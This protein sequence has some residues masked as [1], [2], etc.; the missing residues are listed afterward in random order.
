MPLTLFVINLVFLALISILYLQQ[1]LSVLSTRAFISC[2][3][4]ARASM[5]S[6][7][8]NWSYFC[9]LPT[10]SPCSSRASVII[11]SRKLLKRVSERRHPCL[12][13]T[14]VLNHS[15]CCSS[16]EL[17]HSPQR[18]KTSLV[19]Q[20]FF[21]RRYFPCISLAAL[22]SAVSLVIFTISMSISSS[23]RP[24]SGANFPP[25]VA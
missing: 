11:R 12:T 5:S 24:I 20:G 17:H 3:D 9:H 8:A 23:L 4:S 19:I 7:P 15:L 14:V 2:S 6:E 21:L 22:V 25:T 16:S 10:F 13:P 1:V 18:S